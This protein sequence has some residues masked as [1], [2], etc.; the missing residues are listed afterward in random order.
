MS[1]GYPEKNNPFA[2]DDS[3][4]SSSKTSQYGV[5][6]SGG[7]RDSAP[8]VGWGEEADFDKPRSRYEQLQDMKQNSMNNQLEST[9]RMMSSIYESERM[10]HATAEVCLGL[11]LDV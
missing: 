2:D 11:L 7:G 8:T 6:R 1:R 5:Y 9:Q 3:G 10:G 4:F